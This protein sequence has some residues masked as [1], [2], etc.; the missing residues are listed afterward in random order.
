MSEN[1]RLQDSEQTLDAE[2][3]KARIRRNKARILEAEEKSSTTHGGDKIP[4]EY[5]PAS[6]DLDM[7]Y[8]VVEGKKRTPRESKPETDEQKSPLNK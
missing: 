2:E 1:N 4:N 8:P 5:D 7:N 3:V 6:E